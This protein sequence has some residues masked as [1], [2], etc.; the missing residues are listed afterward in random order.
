MKNIK[1]SHVALLVGSL[2]LPLVA[3]S[4]DN[5][6][7]TVSHHPLFL[8]IEAVEWNLRSSSL[9]P[10]IDITVLDRSI[11]L[12]ANARK[13]MSAGNIRTAEGLL[14]QAARPLHE[15]SSQA[16]TGWHPDLGHRLRE[17]QETLRSLT[18][19]AEKIALEKGAST[20]FTKMAR[21]TLLRSAHLESMAMPGKA[22]QIIEEAYAELTKQ[23]ALLRSG[24][25]FY[26]AIADAP[27]D[28]R[29]SDGLRRFDERKQLTEYLILEAKADEIDT[30][31]L[32]S[33]L[34][35]AEN[36]MQ[37]ATTLA[38]ARDWDEAIKRLELAYVNFEDSWRQV[39]LEW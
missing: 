31:P 15:M 32:Y 4:T 30:T 19:A 26:L 21:S 6:K 28:Q 14:Q 39:G 18:E 20:E 36:S 29:W 24:E 38:N 27:V 2:L 9:S 17:Q 1:F 34:Q 33:G 5:S 37:E 13:E 11:S 10:R 12:L 23:I 7:T 8:Q 3:N 25:Y 16:M 22:L 35:A